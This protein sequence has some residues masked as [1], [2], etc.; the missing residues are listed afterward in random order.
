MAGVKFIH[1]QALCAP[2]SQY[3]IK[4]IQHKKKKHSVVMSHIETASWWSVLSMHYAGLEADHRRAAVGMT[5]KG[6]S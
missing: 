1:S 4:N 6:C 3:K 5:H 2:Q